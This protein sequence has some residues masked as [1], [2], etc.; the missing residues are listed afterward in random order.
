[1]SQPSQMETRERRRRALSRMS[2]FQLAEICR[3]GIT[4]PD[5][6]QVIIE[7]AHPVITWTKD[8]IILSILDVEFRR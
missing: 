2:K 6:S 4:T 8:E 7:G 3:A 5:G 1:M